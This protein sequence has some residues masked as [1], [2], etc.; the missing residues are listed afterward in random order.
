MQRKRGGFTLVEILTVVAIIVI[1][2]TILFPVFSRARENARKAQCASTLKQIG[3]AWR[4]YA[5]DCDGQAMPFSNVVAG[6]TQYWFGLKKEVQY[7]GDTMS[8]SAPGTGLL[9]PWLKLGGTL[10]CPSFPLDDSPYATPDVQS[11]GYNSSVFRPQ[12]DDN[13]H[14]TTATSSIEKPAELVIFADAITVALFN[15]PEPMMLDI[16]TIMAPSSGVPTFHIRHNG[17]GNVLWADGH[18]KAMPATYIDSSRRPARIQQSLQVGF[19]DRDGK[20]AT[21]EYF[22]LNP[23][24]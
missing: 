23:S 7:Q 1:L 16:G 5:N 14:R 13:P 20:A 6:N 21:N 17:M 10:R 15:S 24:D 22:D 2:A 19:I 11:Y 9:S 18:V 8:V 12:T 4:M 3:L